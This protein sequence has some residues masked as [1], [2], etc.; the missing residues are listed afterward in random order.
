MRWILIPKY[1]TSFGLESDQFSNTKIMV[2]DKREE[3][4]I[5]KEILFW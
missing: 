5:E 3:P 1:F 4:M 2:S